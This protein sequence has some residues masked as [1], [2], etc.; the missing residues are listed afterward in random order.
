MAKKKTRNGKSV[1]DRPLDSIRRVK[2][3]GETFTFNVEDLNDLYLLQDI[4]LIEEKQRVDRI[5]PFI[6][7]L[8]GEEQGSRVLTL[9]EDEKGRIQVDAAAK[10]IQNTMEALHPKSQ[11]TPTSGLTTLKR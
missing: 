3:G 9:L 11:S 4:A 1:N 10:F 6:K 7:R 5:I 2:V 8:Y